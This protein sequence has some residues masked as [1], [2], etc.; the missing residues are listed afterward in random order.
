M[1]SMHLQET[2][3]QSATLPENLPDRRGT[4]RRLLDSLRRCQDRLSSRMR[5]T[6]SANSLRDR[7][8]TFGRIPDSL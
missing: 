2:H 4:R 5:F 8:G 6:G 3:R 7:Q 1:S